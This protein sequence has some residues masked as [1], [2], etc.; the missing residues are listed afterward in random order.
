[1]KHS[2]F[3]NN[4]TEYSGSWS[5]RKPQ[6][7]D[8]TVIRKEMSACIK[9]FID[10]LP[11]NYKIVI[12]FRELEDLTNR[13]IADILEKSLDNVKIRLH[14]ARAKLKAALSDGCDFYHNEQNILACDRKSSQILP[15]PPE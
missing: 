9:E 13:E 2:A 4:A 1:M 7:T 6:T 15:K 3:Y 10:N 14:R 8:Q 5:S 11:P 12:A